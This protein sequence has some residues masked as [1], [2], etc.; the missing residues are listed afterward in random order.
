MEDSFSELYET[1]EPKS[2]VYTE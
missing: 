1:G 2:G